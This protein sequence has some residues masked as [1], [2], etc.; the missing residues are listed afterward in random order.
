MACVNSDGTLTVV[1]AQILAALA[2]ADDP[3]DIAMAA[4][5]PMYR[6]RSGLRD[7]AQAG[8]VEPLGTGFAI[9]PRGRQLLQGADRE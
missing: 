5:L 6:V 9:T 3:A 1:A 8:I 7:M 4:G 2:T